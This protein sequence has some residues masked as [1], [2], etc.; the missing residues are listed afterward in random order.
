MSAV[1]AILR[2]DGAPVAVTHVEQQLECLS[3]RG[4]DDKGVWVSGTVGLGHRMRWTTPESVGE[5]L[6]REQEDSS[7]AITCD[8]RLDNR[9]ELIIAL[10]LGGRHADI[11]DSEIVVRAYEKWG[12]DSISQLL[13]DFV[14]VL[15]DERERRLVCAR[16]SMGAKHFYYFYQPGVMFALASEAK[17]LLCLSEV[18][19]EIDE[20]IIG[21]LLILNYNAKEETP[22]KHIRRLPANSAMTVGEKGIRVWKYWSP[23]TESR[24]SKSSA[25]HYEERFRSTF[26]EAVECRMRSTGKVGSMLSGG[27]DSSSISCVA[28]N[29]LVRTEGGPLETFSA[30][31][32]SIAEVDRRIDERHFINAVTERIVCRSNPVTADESSPVR[33]IEKMQWHVDHPIGVP[34]VFMDW[35]L[36]EAAQK[37][38]VG[39]LL[40]GFDGDSTVSYGYEAL[41]EL[42]RRGKWIR[43]FKDSISLGRNM[44][45]RQ[46]E[47]RKLVWNRGFRPVV[48][49]FVREGRRMLLGRPRKLPTGQTLP[50]VNAF[51]YKMLNPDFAERTNLTHRYLEVVEREQPPGAEPADQ[52]WNAICNGL[53]SFALETFEKLGAAFGVEMRF[54]FFDRRLIEYCISLP[55]EQ[56]LY[57]GWTRSILRRAMTGILPPEVQWRT[58][59]ANIGLSFKINLLKYGKRDIEELLSATQSPLGR[60]LD[61]RKVEQAFHLFE[62]DPL[63][64]DGEAMSLMSAICLAKW[65]RSTL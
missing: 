6:P 34:N 10:G 5:K 31:F 58:D 44:P 57:G 19:R 53:F 28:S 25:A 21:D 8:V 3:H 51:G 42:A 64:R 29:H 2:L 26:R 46:H 35:M 15:W 61:L 27:L 13:G 18:P 56:R 65:L 39:V 37:R 41:S 32:P 62:E 55:V 23:K 7:I 16:D 60:F 4:S 17:A 14:F 30:V 59:K 33:D 11:T 45:R 52:W 40:S 36:F 43:M 49:D 9:S 12:L 20:E 22:Y 50:S 1:T 54:P 48:P 24:G 47:F 38:D 63:G